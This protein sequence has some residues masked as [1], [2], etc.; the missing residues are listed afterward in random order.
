MNRAQKIRMLIG[1]ASALMA[2]DREFD[3]TR[4]LAIADEI[5]AMFEQQHENLQQLFADR[6]SEIT[7]EPGFDELLTKCFDILKVKGG[8]YT[9]GSKDRLHNFRTVA[10]FT[11]LSMYQVLSVYFYKHVAAVFA[12]LKSGGQ[13]ESEPIEG[14]MADVINYM[15]LMNLMVREKRDAQGT[16]MNPE[17][18]QTPPV[19]ARLKWTDDVE[20]RPTVAEIER[21][22]DL[23][24]QLLKT[25]SV[26]D[27]V[28][29]LIDKECGVHAEP[30]VGGMHT[31][32]NLDAF[33]QP[34]ENLPP[35]NPM[36]SQEQPI[37]YVPTQLAKEFTSVESSKSLPR[38]LVTVDHGEV[39][40]RHKGV[41]YKLDGRLASAGDIAEFLGS[42]L[43]CEVVVCDSGKW[44]SVQPEQVVN[45]EPAVEL[46]PPKC[47]RCAAALLNNGSCP[48]ACTV[49]PVMQGSTTSFKPVK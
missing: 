47:A 22:I 42:M 17:W 45:I 25:V 11:G 49:Q 12:F 40:I 37:P 48:F 29:D 32:A 44:A 23:H 7:G 30:I 4:A 5:E 6:Q 27:P 9:I 36:V 39:R 26:V 31:S 2:G 24:E 28:A 10:E 34:F 15:L 19:Y 8:D 46:E 14:R 3:T 18:K 41:Q 13:S 21:H 33:E 20:K 38:D 16:P 43:K 1:E 35:S